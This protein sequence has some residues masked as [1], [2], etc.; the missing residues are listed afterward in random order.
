M[1]TCKN[2]SAENLFLNNF[3]K[4]SKIGKDHKTLT[5]AFAYLLTIIVKVLFCYSL[6][7]FLF[8]NKS[9]VVRQLVRQAGHNFLYTNYQVVPY[10]WRLKSVLKRKALKSWSN[11]QQ[12]K[13]P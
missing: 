10:L 5:S 3:R 13:R 6:N 1:L 2:Y 12:I 4:A 7:I 11:F 9:S 8:S